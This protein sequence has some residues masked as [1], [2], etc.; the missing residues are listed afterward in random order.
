M[1]DLQRKALLHKQLRQFGENWIHK[2]DQAG[3]EVSGRP[4]DFD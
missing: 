3:S 2:E 1:L 4:D